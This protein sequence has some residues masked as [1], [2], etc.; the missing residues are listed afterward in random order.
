MLCYAMLC[1][2]LDLAVDERLRE[3]IQ[4]RWGG[5]GRAHLP[6]DLPALSSGDVG[7]GERYVSATHSGAAATAAQQTPHLRPS[8]KAALPAIAAFELTQLPRYV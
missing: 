4:T 8:C 2:A 1:K 3:I 5:G 7:G 6:R